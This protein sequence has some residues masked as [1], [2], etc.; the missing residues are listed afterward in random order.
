MLRFRTFLEFYGETSY[1][2]PDDRK[3]QIFDFYMLNMI[4]GRSYFDKPITKAIQSG[5]PIGL[6]RGF[7]PSLDDDRIGKRPEQHTLEDKIDVAIEETSKILLTHLKTQLLKE[8]LFAITS[9]IRHVIDINPDAKKLL[10]KVKSSEEERETEKLNPEEIAYLRAYLIKWVS[11]GNKILKQ[12]SSD[13]QRRMRGEKD[14][15][16]D[17]YNA[18]LEAKIPRTDFVILCKK[19]FKMPLWAGAYGGEPWANICQGWLDLQKSTQNNQLFIQIDHVYDLIHNTNTVFNK[20]KDYFKSG[21]DWIKTTLDFKAK[22]KSPYELLP[23]V[24]PAMKKIALPAIRIK[25]HDTLEDYEKR[26]AI[27]DVEKTIASSLETPDVYTKKDKLTK[28]GRIILVLHETTKMNFEDIYNQIILKNDK[29]KN[30][31]SKNEYESAFNK[32]RNI[33]AYFADK[34]S[35]LQIN[36]FTMKSF[37]NIFKNAPNI[38]LFDRE[39][40]I[41]KLSGA[42]TYAAVASIRKLTG[43]SENAS[44][45]IFHY[46]HFLNHKNKTCNCDQFKEK[47]IVQNQP[48]QAIPTQDEIIDKAINLYNTDFIDIPHP[49]KRAVRLISYLNPKNNQYLIEGLVKYISIKPGNDYYGMDYNYILATMKKDI[50][51]FSKILAELGALPSANI[52][53]KIFNKRTVQ[54]SI[55]IIN[56]FDSNKIFAVKIIQ[57]KKDYSG[58]KSFLEII[59]QFRNTEKVTLLFAK[60]YIQLLHSKLHHQHICDCRAKSI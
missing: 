25:F 52:G 41:F 29:W 31:L 12:L 40:Q 14:S 44:T 11:K 26:Q 50:Y 32:E 37:D 9:E 6:H 23:F 27:E 49:I 2:V 57:Q 22:I 58:Y 13:Q 30:L 10:S 55:N 56:Y 20:L 54:N 18:F 1:Q 39:N 36:Q 5:V 38:N 51:N 21:Y 28:G 3:Q 17:S 45:V 24:S 59:K 53:E 48:T 15:Y 42:S 7:T 35:L 46:M 34:E 43:F 60:N 8:I 16:R 47:N 19:L 4:S 33:E